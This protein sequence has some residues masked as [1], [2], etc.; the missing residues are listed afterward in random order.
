MSM[1][2]L[3]S[4]FF[5]ANCPGT[6]DVTVLG[7]RHIV[8]SLSIGTADRMDRRQVNDIEPHRGGRPVKLSEA[9]SHRVWH[10]WQ[11]IAGESSEGRGDSCGTGVHSLSVSHFSQ[12]N[13]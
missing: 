11:Q 1:N 7:I 8:L 2:G 4:A 13:I 12:A 3:V 5:G 6:S 9:D 10:A